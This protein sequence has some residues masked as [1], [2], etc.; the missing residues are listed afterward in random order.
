MTNQ[1]PNLTPLEVFIDPG[2]YAATIAKRSRWG[3]AGAMVALFFALTASSVSLVLQDEDLVADYTEKML[4]RPPDGM[5]LERLE[6]IRESTRAALAMPG[7]TVILGLVSGAAT[8][9]HLLATWIVIACG[10]A[11]AMKTSTAFRP[12]ILVAAASLP[13]LMLGTIVNLLLRLA[14]RDL[15]AVAGLL[16]T[17]GARGTTS[18]AGSFAASVDIFV[19]WY[20]TAVAFGISASI[21]IRIGKALLVVFAL[22][23]TVLLCSFL[24]GQG[25]GWT[26]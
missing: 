22:W 16:P 10:V 9:L 21:P 7:M 18:L 4:R 12:V 11:I 13:I 2:G 6:G 26:M 23:A 24:M 19:V 15:T 5:T 8:L 14:F 1:D 20:L 25:A 17:L 3:L